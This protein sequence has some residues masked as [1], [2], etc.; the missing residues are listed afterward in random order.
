MHFKRPS[1]VSGPLHRKPG[2]V[3]D[4]GINSHIFSD[5]ADS[6]R[7]HAKDGWLRVERTRVAPHRREWRTGKRDT[8]PENE[9]CSLDK[10]E[11]RFKSQ[12]HAGAMPKK[13][14]RRL[15]LAKRGEKLV[16]SKTKA[17]Q[18]SKR[19]TAAFN[20]MRAKAKASVP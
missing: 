10:L 15:S 7:V 18:K 16:K 14:C 9:V 6:T 4:L 3:Y 5:R 2:L 12:M 13:S 8:E 17:T 11:R 1:Y 20:A 19:V